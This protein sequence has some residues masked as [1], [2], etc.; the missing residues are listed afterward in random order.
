[1]HLT[2]FGAGMRGES[3]HPSLWLLERVLP[4]SALAEP[5][6]VDATREPMNPNA[7]VVRWIIAKPSF[8]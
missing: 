5:R 8:D 6:A 3:C 7:R 1:M 4:E 2:A